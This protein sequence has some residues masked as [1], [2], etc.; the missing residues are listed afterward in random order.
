MSVIDEV[1]QRIDIVD[2]VGQYAKLTKSGRNLR[3]VCPFHDEKTPS[4]FVFPEKQSWHCFGACSTGGDVFSFVMKREGIEFGEALRRLADRAGVAIPSRIE[5][6][7]KKEARDRIYE[8]NEAAAAYFQELLIRSPAGEKARDYLKGRGLNA[9]AMAAFQLGFALDSWDGLKNRLKERGF[10]ETELV[11]AGLLS[12]SENGRVYDRWRNRIMFPIKDERG[13]TTG[14]GAR[15]LESSIEGPKYINTA[16]TLVFDKSGTLYGLNL[17][18]HEIRQQDRAVIVEGYMDVIAAHQYGFKN[19]VASMGTSIT[20][21]QVN[22]LKKLSKNLVLALD[23][24]SAG[25]EAMLRCVDHENTLE[26]EIKVVILPEGKDPDD[27]I[28]ADAATWSALVNE[29]SPVTDYT[30]DTVASHMDLTKV[31]ERAK[32]RDRLYPVVSSIE[33]VVR[34]AHYLQKLARMLG[35]TDSSLEASMRKRGLAPGKGPSR[36]GD[37]AVKVSDTLFRSAIEEYCLTLLL[38][39]P[40]LRSLGK[41]TDPDYFENSENRQ[42]FLAWCDDSEGSLEN[43]QKTVDVAIHDHLSRLAGKIVPPSG[44]ERKYNDCVLR[45]REQFLRNLERKRE[46]LLTGEVGSAMELA[47]SKEVSTELKRI[48]EMKA[49]REQGLRS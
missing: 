3:A 38:R 21:K 44:I 48:F 32:A 11:D 12:T 1:K 36:T 25:S 16:Q 40:E 22:A 37:A 43:V 47:K 26:T 15:I 7:G 14:F 39:F 29:A 24:D 41:A 9:E 5:M 49:R 35:V 2:V 45:L 27:V 13:R 4:F 20:D 18:A 10:T 46:A 28:K 19:V 34:R 8:A 30:F 33:D 42:I 6:D 23:S 17:A 31:G